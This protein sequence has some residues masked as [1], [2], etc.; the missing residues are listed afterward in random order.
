MTTTCPAPESVTVTSATSGD[1][2]GGIDDA[3]LHPWGPRNDAFVSGQDLMSFAQR[4]IV[5]LM[6]LH[7]GWDHGDGVPVTPRSA[8]A[9]LWLLGVLIFA[10]NLATPQISPQS[11]GGLDIEWLVSGNHLSLAIG[12]DDVVTLWATNADGAEMFS[13]DSSGDPP[14]AFSNAMAR[15]RQFLFEI[16]TGVHNRV[17]LW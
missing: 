1:W 11:S 16:S 2:A 17:A 15:A 4:Q 7:H 13:F 12:G 9:A 5:H 10:D 6:N 3:H 14:L 8:K